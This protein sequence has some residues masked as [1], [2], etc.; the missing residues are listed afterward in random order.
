MSESD[1]K[2]PAT[3][4]SDS[5]IGLVTV[6]VVDRIRAGQTPPYCIHGETWCVTCRHAVW[7]GTATLKVVQEG[8]LP[9]CMECAEEQTEALHAAK[10]HHH[11]SDHQR[12]DG[13]HE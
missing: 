6:V 9:L 3:N 12:A 7:L 11:V 2:S 8:A 10:S 4:P 1:R 13:P 5:P